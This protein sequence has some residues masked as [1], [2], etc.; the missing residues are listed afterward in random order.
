MT[1][2]GFIHDVAERSRMCCAMFVRRASDQK[3]DYYRYLSVA[4]AQG[5]ANRKL[6]DS[7]WSFA[8]SPIADTTAA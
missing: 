5:P 3:G 2:G 4:I 7:L 6:N 1:N 8:L